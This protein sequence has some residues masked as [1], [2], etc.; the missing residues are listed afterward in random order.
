MPKPKVK[1]VVLAYSGGL[2]TSLLC[3]ALKEADSK[4]VVA[5]TLGFPGRPHD[6]T[7][8]A[9][10]VAELKSFSFEAGVKRY[11]ALRSK[12]NAVS[13]NE[14]IF[15]ATLAGGKSESGRSEA[16]FSVNAR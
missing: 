6:E 1:K 14:M 3:A 10:A 9:R 12:I 11:C 15:T 5:Y 13:F 2:D 16:I 4:Q 7:P 8:Y